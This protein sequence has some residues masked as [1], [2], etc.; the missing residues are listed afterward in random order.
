MDPFHANTRRLAHAQRRTLVVIRNPQPM[1]RNRFV[2]QSCSAHALAH[3]NKTLT[4]FKVMLKKERILI[5][6]PY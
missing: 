4:S 3:Q 6:I 5:R 1:S 2:Q